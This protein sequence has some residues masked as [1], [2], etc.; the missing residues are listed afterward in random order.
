MPAK[1]RKRDELADAIERLGAKR[2]PGETEPD[3]T[4]QKRPDVFAVPELIAVAPE[5]EWLLDHK[6]RRSIPHKLQRCG[7]LACR[8]PDS[9]EGKWR[10]KGQEGDAVRKRSALDF[11]AREGSESVFRCCG[12]SRGNQRAGSFNEQSWH[13][14]A[15]VALGAGTTATGLTLTSIRARACFW[16]R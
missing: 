15:L 7:Y 9:K 3:G 16:K 1:R 5:L 12:L 10:V 8:N 4:E 14:V 13:W 11:R 6:R 2:H